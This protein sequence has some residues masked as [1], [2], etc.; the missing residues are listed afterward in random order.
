MVDR[1]PS[2]GSRRSA[3]YPL[4]RAGDNAIRGSA[5]IAGFAASIFS[6][7]SQVA[8]ITTSVRGGAAAAAPASTPPGKRSAVP[9]AA[10]TSRT[11]GWSSNERP[12]CS[13]AF[14][15]ATRVSRA[16][17]MASR[18]SRGCC[19]RTT[20]VRDGMGPSPPQTQKV[21]GR[22]QRR[23]VARTAR[24]ESTDAGGRSR[25][26]PSSRPC[27]HGCGA[28]TSI[29]AAPRSA[30]FS[31]SEKRKASFVSQLGSRFT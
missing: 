8:S 31:E 18:A 6:A 27:G 2:A 20:R 12:R 13:S 21:S 23:Q 22:R 4:G 29:D 5:A 24:E 30:S 26:W 7:W 25:A 3:P 15:S 16:E 14:S 10:T 9:S 28:S 1:C 19:S 17:Q 11:R